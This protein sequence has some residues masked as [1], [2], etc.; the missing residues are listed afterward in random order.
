VNESQS[1]FYS[2]KQN[3][4][5]VGLMGID[6]NSKQQDESILKDFFVDVQSKEYS[7]DKGFSLFIHMM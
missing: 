2:L 3:G 4:K 5:I 7:K 6:L 1:N